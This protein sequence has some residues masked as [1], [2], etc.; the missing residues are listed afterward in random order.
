VKKIN[1]DGTAIVDRDAT[2]AGVGRVTALSTDKAFEPISPCGTS[3]AFAESF[4]IGRRSASTTIPLR[5]QTPKATA[6]PP[7]ESNRLTPQEIDELR[8]S[9]RRMGE[10]MRAILDKKKQAEAK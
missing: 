1:I 9:A 5:G 3:K 4:F 7:A 8:E 2:D 6:E 10:K